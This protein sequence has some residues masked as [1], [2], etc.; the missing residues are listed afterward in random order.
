[1]A[2]GKKLKNAACQK[3][4]IL[5]LKIIDM[6]NEG[7]GVARKEG[8]TLFVKDAI[9][10]DV[11][12]GKVMKARKNF[13]YV[14][15]LDILTPSPY[16]VEPECP[17]SRQC[18]GCQLQ[19]CSYD[20]QLEWKEE[21]IA[22]CLRR[23]GGQAV[24]TP[25]EAAAGRDKAAENALEKIPPVNKVAEGALEKFP[26]VDKVAETA[27]EKSAPGEE[28]AIVMEPIMGMEQPRHY[29]NK[30][31]FP[32]GMNREG[33]LAVGFYAGRT[34]QIVENRD[35]M[36]QHPCNRILI[37]AVLEYMEECGVAAYDEVAHRGLV[38]H[39]LI[40]VGVHTGEVMLCLVI[41]GKKLPEKDKLVEKILSLDLSDCGELRVASICLNNNMEKTNAILGQEVSVLSGTKYIEDRI[42][43]I[44]FRI[45]PLS[46]YQVNPEQTK[47]LYDTALEYAELTGE[48]VVWDLYCGIGTISLF[49]AQRAKKVCGVEIVPQA[50]EDAR[51][52]ARLNGIENVEFFAGAAEDVVPAKYEESSGTLRADVVVVDPPR[53]GCDE[54]LLRTVVQMRPE[55]I[56][57]VSCDPA[58]LA[59]D[60]K[61]LGEN[62]YGMERVR[63]C[64]MFGMGYHVETVVQLSLK[65][66]APKIEVTMEPEEES[67][68]TPEEKATY[69]KIREYVKEKYGVDVHTSYIAEVKRMCG[70]D[71][72]E[73]YNK[74]KKE[75]SVVRHC[76]Q[77]KVVY[78]KD[79]LK[80][81]G[82]I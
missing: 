40:R 25:R 82:L 1:M 23:I 36:I 67:Y 76:P 26:P 3:N 54:T 71:M 75:N 34:H 48:E 7:E 44:T 16:R 52:N 49:L 47:K 20:R 57:Y 55:R 43:D 37:D 70:L 50:V 58:T 59:R 18:G 29:R 15:L 46:F 64:D 38:R 65:K 14:K 24:L 19:H 2:K 42:G 6:G 81:Y 21:K 53:K 33:K 41:N 39:I 5:I 68:Y 78:I 73:N 60:V 61:Y 12:R 13:G 45:S 62:G 17:V 11:I 56:V 77:E 74:F 79:A 31:Q 8:Y 72:G 69:P 9:T 35:C 28:G 63:G 80:Y 22:N 30:A 66:D 32:V 10:G 27:F 4:D 51:E